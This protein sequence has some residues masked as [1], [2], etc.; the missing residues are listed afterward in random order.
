MKWLL[1]T[2]VIWK[3]GKRRPQAGVK[4]NMDKWGTDPCTRLTGSSPVL[5]ATSIRRR[6][7]K[8]TK[9]VRQV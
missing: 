2:N 1:D 3:L 7:T 4:C 8:L 9:S 5:R 6:L